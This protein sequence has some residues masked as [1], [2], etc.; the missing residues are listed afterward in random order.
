MKKILEDPLLN[1]IESEQEYQK[2]LARY[3]PRLS[4]AVDPSSKKFPDRNIV[5]IN[6]TINISN[7]AKS[8]LTQVSVMLE[9]DKKPPPSKVKLNFN[10]LQEHIAEQR[11]KDK[12]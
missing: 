7:K 9:K 6:K 5:N 12:S 11:N 4:R 8:I 2:E 1:V 3:D 10:N